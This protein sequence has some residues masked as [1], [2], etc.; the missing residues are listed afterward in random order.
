MS[1]FPW[2]LPGLRPSPVIQAS[3]V[4]SFQYGA[5][6][7]ERITGQE[8]QVL[9]AVR[10][11]LEEAQSGNPPY[12]ERQAQGRHAGNISSAARCCQRLRGQVSIFNFLQG[13][14]IEN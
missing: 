4:V 7:E 2:Q 6:D 3:S 11:L 1:R 9:R 12:D 13:Q 8:D 10:G 5:H 14:K